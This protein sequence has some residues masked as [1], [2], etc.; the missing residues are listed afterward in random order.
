[1]F[2]GRFSRVALLEIDA[3]LGGHA[4]QRYR[5][6]IKTGGV[7]STWLINVWEHRSYEHEVAP[8]ERTLIPALYI[9]PGR[10]AELQRS[11]A[12][13]GHPRFFPQPCGRI[14]AATCKIT[15]QATPGASRTGSSR[16]RLPCRRSSDRRMGVHARGQLANGR[17]HHCCSQGTP[18]PFPSI[19]VPGQCFTKNFASTQEVIC[20]P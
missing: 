7:D 9:H 6:L 1:M 20:E 13:S 16:R 4:H 10:L 2:Q 12:R 19:F 5:I 17:V 14:S 15:E 3:G 11:L 8:G 18:S